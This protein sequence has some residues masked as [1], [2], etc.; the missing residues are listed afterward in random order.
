MHFDDEIDT[1]TGDNELS[2]RNYNC[3]RNT[4]RWPM[5]I[6]YSLLN[7]AGINSLIIF[8]SNN[9]SEDLVRRKFLMQL[10]RQLVRNRK[11]EAAGI[12][13]EQR[14]RPERGK[15]KRCEECTPDSNTSY[16]CKKCYKYLCLSH[17]NI[18]CKK[19]EKG[20]LLQKEVKKVDNQAQFQREKMEVFKRKRSK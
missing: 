6:L 19:C 2:T 5:V 20:Y 18:F 3:A 8:S 17:A 13:Q 12:S 10:V 15:R 9:P 14:P 4:R 7:I 11:Q 1:R 16:Y